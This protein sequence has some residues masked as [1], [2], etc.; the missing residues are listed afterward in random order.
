VE[1]KPQGFRLVHGEHH[2]PILDP[3]FG[4]P[5]LA[6]IHV[7]KRKGSKA[8]RQ[9]V[10]AAIVGN[11]E[12]ALKGDAEHRVRVHVREGKKERIVA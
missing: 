11:A 12:G 4:H 2:A 9:R 7:P 5:L 3:A 10:I 8:G 1:G 6:V